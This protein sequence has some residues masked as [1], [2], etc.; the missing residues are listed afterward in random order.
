MY[1]KYVVYR[2]RSLY[3]L[4]KKYR[5]L[6]LGSKSLISFWTFPPILPKFFSFL[7]LIKIWSFP[8]YVFFQ[9]CAFIEIGEIFHPMHL[10]H[11][12]LLSVTVWGCVQTTWTE[13]WAIL[14]PLPPMWTLL[15]NSLIKC[16]GHLGNPPP[17]S[18][19]HVVCTW[20]LIVSK[21]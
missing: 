7:C 3:T 4:A 15:L 6:F 21:K 2:L 13:F 10:F 11:P 19:V 20:P 1:L 16:C 17:P 8:P 12:V 5:I 18:F 9:Y 14:T